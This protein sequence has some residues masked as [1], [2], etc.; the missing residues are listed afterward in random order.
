MFTLTA[1]V[2]REAAERVCK[3]V[4]ARIG[5][6]PPTD[7][8]QPWE[9]MVD[10]YLPVEVHVHRGRCFFVGIVIDNLGPDPQET[11]SRALKLS[12]E[13]CALGAAT[14]SLDHD[15]R[16]LILWKPANESG[17][18]EDILRAFGVLLKELDL[19]FATL[20]DI[21]SRRSSLPGGFAGLAG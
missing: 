16:R 6:A 4:A 12:R 9:L 20:I 3:L 8:S 19:W 1:E 18:D 2:Q 15:H 10:G 17:S 13:R 5:T 14:P 21:P 11:L 7:F